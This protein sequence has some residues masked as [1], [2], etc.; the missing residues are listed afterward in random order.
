MSEIKLI[1]IYELMSERK[2]AGILFSQEKLFH[3]PPRYTYYNG[4]MYVIE[5]KK[6]NG[7]VCKISYNSLFK[8]RRIKKIEKFE[9]MI[10]N[11]IDEFND[12]KCK[13]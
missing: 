6:N 4:K 5:F 10:S 1:R 8:C 3:Y 11:I 12:F 9:F 2:S 7:E 13:I